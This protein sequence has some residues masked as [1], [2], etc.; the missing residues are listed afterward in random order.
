VPGFTQAG[1]AA[2]AMGEFAT[3]TY[4][5]LKK[6]VPVGDVLHGIG[7]VGT[8]PVHPYVVVALHHG[9]C[10]PALDSAMDSLSLFSSYVVAALRWK[11]FWLE[12]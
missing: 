5:N 4:K 6:G 1:A 9:F 10:H 7:A 12:I 2:V 3:H 8:L 11:P